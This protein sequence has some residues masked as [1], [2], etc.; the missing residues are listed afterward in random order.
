MILQ[1]GE[2]GAFYSGQSERGDAATAPVHVSLFFFQLQ[3]RDNQ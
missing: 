2:I 3:V 1:A